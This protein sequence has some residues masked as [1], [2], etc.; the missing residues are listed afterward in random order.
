MKCTKCGVE[1]APGITECDAAAVAQ[2]AAA[3]PPE[4]ANLTAAD[5]GKAVADAMAQFNTG[6][7]PAAGRPVGTGVQVNEG[8][9]YIFDGL[10]HEHDFSTDLFAAI[11]LGPAGNASPEAYKRVMQFMSEEMSPIDKDGNI[12]GANFVTTSNT[13]AINPSGYR[14]DM[15]VDYQKWTTPLRNA[16]FKGSLSDV[17]PFAFPKFN[18]SSGLVGDHTE[19]TEPT[20]G[21]FSVA[22]GGTVTPAPVS[23]EVFITREVADQGGNPQVSQLIWNRVQY[24]YLQAMET[25]CAALLAALSPAEWPAA[26]AVAASTVATLAAPLEAAVAG[27]NFVIGG[28]R[29][30]LVATHKD[31]YLAMVALKDGQTRPY[32]PQLSP[33]NANGQITAGAKSLDVMGKPFSPVWSLGVTTDGTPHKSYAIDTSVTYFWHTAPTRLD[34][35][36]EKV[37]GYTLGVWGYQAGAVTDASGVLKITYDPS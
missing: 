24:D 4:A 25:K 17:T 28:D 36:Q 26:L 10:D 18:A 3:N 29:F 35:L 30:D 37:A 16:F 15:Y 1:H 19:G 21:S 5:I 20:P 23:G 13:T 2:F 14:P 6:P 22:S 8:S 31:L 9:P 33:M 11:G 7:T 27:L 12:K 34:R 32:F